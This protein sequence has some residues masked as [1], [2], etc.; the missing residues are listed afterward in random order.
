MSD[1]M[2]KFLEKQKEHLKNI[3]AE[4][5]RRERNCRSREMRIDFAEKYVKNSNP[6]KTIAIPNNHWGKDHS[7]AIQK[8]KDSISML[9][10]D[11]PE[12]T[13]IMSLHTVQDV[14][15]DIPTHHAT[16]HHDTSHNHTHTDC[17]SHSHGSCD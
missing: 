4:L 5:S 15:P 1:K 11:S 10:T 12:F 7:E 13:K 17:S 9:T 2:L 3:D 16:T 14:Q 8:L 6:W